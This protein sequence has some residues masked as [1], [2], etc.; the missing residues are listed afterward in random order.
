MSTSVARATPCPASKVSLAKRMTSM[1]SS[2]INAAFGTIELIAGAKLVIVNLS[3][4][5]RI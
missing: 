5:P 1:A 2:V 4:N 3:T